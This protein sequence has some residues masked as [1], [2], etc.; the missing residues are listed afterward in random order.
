MIFPNPFQFAYAMLRLA[1]ARAR[2]YETIVTPEEHEARQSV[3]Y[4]CPFL[5]PDFGQ[6]GVCGCDVDAKT[7]LTTEECPKGF[8]RSIWRKRR[9]T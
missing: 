5:D 4:G 3:C 6:C 2:G 8:W 7:L 1:W 9:T